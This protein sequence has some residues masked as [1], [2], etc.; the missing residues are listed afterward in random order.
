[1]FITVVYG[2]AILTGMLQLLF[3]KKMS[4]FS[5]PAGLQ[6]SCCVCAFFNPGNVHCFTL[7]VCYTWDV[8]QCSNHIVVSAMGHTVLMPC[9][10]VLRQWLLRQKRAISIQF[11]VPL[12]QEKQYIGLA[13]GVTLG[14]IQ[15]NDSVLSK[16]KMM[17]SL[18]EDR[19]A[20]MCLCWMMLK[21]LHSVAT[22]ILLHLCN[23]AVLK[24]GGCHRFD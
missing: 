7:C 24:G 22:H 19:K 23:T 20:T 5:V 13:V 11:L 21:Q 9:S 1:M 18:P 2:I 15:S 10:R 6:L 4:G 17:Y 8:S 16:Q 3:R 14:Q 12:C